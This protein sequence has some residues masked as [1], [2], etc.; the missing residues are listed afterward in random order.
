[1]NVPK[2]SPRLSPSIFILIAT[3]IPLV[4]SFLTPFSSLPVTTPIPT[5][6]P[7][8]NNPN[9]PN[10]FYVKSPIT[11]PSSSSL[12]AY[13]SH[14]RLKSP[15]SSSSSSS[16][17]KI[18]SQSQIP[19]APP[20]EEDEDEDED[21]MKVMSKSDHVRGYKITKDGKKT[22][23][24]THEQTE[25]EKALIG[26]I[27]PKRIDSAADA[28]TPAALKNEKGVSSWNSA[29]TWE[30]KDMS[31]WA[32]ESMKAKLEGTEYNGGGVTV[33]T[34]K[35]ELEEASASVATVRGKRRFLYEFVIVMHWEAEVEGT[36]GTAKGE[37]RFNDVAPDCDGEF[38]AD[39][40][41]TSMDGEGTKIIRERVKGDRK[42]YREKIED[43]INEWAEAFI[44]TYS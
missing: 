44:K 1:M 43:R 19:P 29:G 36:D 4:S 33:K 26:D 40:K 6:I 12:T 2:N 38:E 16:S 9:K 27:A 32:D 39:I 11:L 35:I 28:A 8:T 20:T 13:L 14:T 34:T 31:K 17:S 41:V 42:S 10:R 37:L 18:K 21:G 22:S 15:S 3:L 5:S 24:F 23:F 7:T 30:E 25:E